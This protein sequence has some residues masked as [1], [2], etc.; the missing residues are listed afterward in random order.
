[1][2]PGRDFMKLLKG[3]AAAKVGKAGLKTGATTALGATI[4]SL[5]LR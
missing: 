1:M 4:L 2:K 5:G 3:R